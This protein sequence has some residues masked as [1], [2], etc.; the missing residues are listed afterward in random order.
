MRTRLRLTRDGET[1]VSLI[2][3]VQAAAFRRALAFLRGRNLGDPALAVQLGADAKAVDAL[4][5]RF[6]GEHETS[7]ELRLTPQDL[8]TL[9]SALTAAAVMF[10]ERNMFSEEDF[11]R[12][13]TFYRE[14]FDALA[15]GIVEAVAEAGDSLR[16]RGGGG[17]S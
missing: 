13:L 4:A 10:L 2:T 14:N 9:H 16:I 11:H 17:G 1:Y 3:P 6:A 5:D 7:F 8:H 12:E 15:L